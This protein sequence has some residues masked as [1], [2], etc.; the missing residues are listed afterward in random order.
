[1]NPLHCMQVSVHLLGHIRMLLGG[2]EKGLVGVLLA[3]RR[4]VPTLHG[5]VIA[6][7]L[8]RSFLLHDHLQR[9]PGD[10]MHKRPAL[11]N[12]INCPKLFVVTSC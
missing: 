6:V 1:M 4:R 8:L 12:G 11:P 10:A 9:L 2:V 3:I 5:R 7:V